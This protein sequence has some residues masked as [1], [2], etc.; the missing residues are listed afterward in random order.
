MT[1]TRIQ[2][3]AEFVKNV[4][5]DVEVLEDQ[6]TLE[7]VKT[8]LE[9]I[10]GNPKLINLSIFIPENSP[11]EDKIPIIKQLRIDR[12]NLVERPRSMY[13]R[14]SLIHKVF[15]VSNPDWLECRKTVYLNYFSSRNPIHS[16][17]EFNVYPSLRA[18]HLSKSSDTRIICPLRILRTCNIVRNC[19]HNC[20]FCYVPHS[21]A[22]KMPIVV[23]VNMPEKVEKQIKS[24]REPY[25]MTDFGSITD[26]GNSLFDDIFRVFRDTYQVLAKYNYPSL[27]LTKAA[28]S[29]TLID[30]LKFKNALLA[31]S[32]YHLDPN[33]K[34]Q[35]ELNTPSPQKIFESMKY[36]QKVGVRIALRIDVFPGYNDDI[37][38]LRKIVRLSKLRGDIEH[39]VAG[40]FRGRPGI[41]RQIKEQN[42]QAFRSLMTCIDKEKYSDNALR[43]IKSLRLKWYKA[44]KET[45][46]ENEISFSLC[47]EEEDLVREFTSEWLSDSVPRCLCNRL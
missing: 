21:G 30:S 35:W 42:Q 4:I 34:R 39:V 45:C 36:A 13:K 29:R 8:F 32:L 22:P 31:F 19:M 11:K 10:T 25:V 23:C 2:R 12:T 17:R 28:P 6:T 7:R 24:S 9:Y 47:K 37:S 38:L 1:K 14:Y 43:P 20:I 5:I 44:L 40:S 41:L 26:P 33:I 15:G 16:P 18:S 46:K 27:I 3:L